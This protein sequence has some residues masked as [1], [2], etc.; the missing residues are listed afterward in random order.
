MFQEILG[1]VWQAVS[2]AFSVSW[3]LIIPIILGS[4]LWERFRYYTLIN[5]FKKMK[6]VTL[7]I[8]IPQIIE[9]TPKAMEQVF[10]ALHASYVFN[11][12]WT[13]K[14][15]KGKSQEWYSI[16]MVGIAGGIYFYIR[17]SENHRNLVES[18]IY[19]QYPDAEISEVDDY[20]S[21]LPSIIPNK[22]YDL[23][24]TDLIL[25]R[26][27]G[28]PIRTYPAFEEKKDEALLD[29]MAGIAEVMSRLKEGEMILLQF[30]IRPTNDDWKKK[31]EETRDKVMGRKKPK[32][33]GFADDA[34]D[35]IGSFFKGPFAE[36]EFKKKDE[37]PMTENLMMGK[38]PGEKEI[39]EGIEKKMAK[40]AFDTRIRFIYIDRRESFSRGYISAVLGAF[41]QYDTRD[42]NY[43]RPDIDTMTK[44]KFPFK[45]R[46]AE[47]K[48]RKIFKAYR[49]RMMGRKNSIM[50]VEE[51]ATIF[52][53][54]AIA[55]KSPMLRRLSSR[56]G[57]PPAGLPM[58]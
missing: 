1:G 50:N 41:R 35:L 25:G 46:K 17:T 34:K 15:F 33:A 19:A 56:K 51:L 58:E 4:V 7:E 28:F 16:E 39:I 40:L 5:F 53:F 45:A 18:A 9:K 21:N 43:F 20:V 2:K 38:T 27:D 13:E 24:G 52:H 47:A 12:K 32:K 44:G 11:I 8:R 26:D 31:A 42:M 6:W 10:A 23:W 48:K 22:T 30:L 55:V 29:P 14:N 37:K 36:V 49:Y 3:W 54:P 57:E